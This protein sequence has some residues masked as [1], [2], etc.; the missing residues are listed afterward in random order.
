MR[1]VVF[2]GVALLG[3]GPAAPPPADPCAVLKPADIQA[4]AG[5]APVGPK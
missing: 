4:L 5:S 1:S 2:V 3:A